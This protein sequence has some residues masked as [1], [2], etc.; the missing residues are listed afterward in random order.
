MKIED[1]DVRWSAYKQ[2]FLK[3]VDAHRKLAEKR[4]AKLGLTK[5][6]SSE[7]PESN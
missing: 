6:P 3:Q 1:P 5:P 7:P 4:A 2:E